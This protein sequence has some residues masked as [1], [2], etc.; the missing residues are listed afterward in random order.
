M[1][2]ADRERWDKVHA[3]KATAGEPSGFL[4]IIFEEFSELLQPGKA[5]DLACGRGRNTFFLA[6]HGWQV[7]AWDISP[8]AIASIAETAQRSGLSI[9]PK[10]VEL[11]QVEIISGSY[12][13]I[14][15][16]NFLERRL[17]SQVKRASKP[18]GFVIF[19][20][21]LIDRQQIGHPKNPD[22]L[23]RHNELLDYFRSFRVHFSREGRFSDGREPAYRAGLFAQRLF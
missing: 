2:D 18:G 8:A 21:F 1:S 13:L 12:D 15:N 7:D 3:T 4:R 14:V 22:F 11:E 5:L 9:A 16:I 23:L 19:E 20:T 17:M 10:E 6:E